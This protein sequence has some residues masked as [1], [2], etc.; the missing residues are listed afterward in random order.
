MALAVGSSAPDFKTT[1]QDGNE[2]KLSDFRGKKVVLYFYP[3]DMTPGCTAEACSLRDNYKALQKAKGTLHDHL[4]CT[5][6]V[7][8]S[9]RP[10]ILSLQEGGWNPPR[11]ID[12]PEGMGP[13]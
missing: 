9:H 2:I 12:R 6:R 4:R 11:F 13:E 5:D 3:K 7:C 1:D 8:T 10:D